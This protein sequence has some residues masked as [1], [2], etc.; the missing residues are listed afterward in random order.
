M[1]F[2]HIPETE[3]NPIPQR[4]NA[5]I[6]GLQH[7]PHS[8]GGAGTERVRRR[9]PPNFAR[10]LI[11]SP[12]SQARCCLLRRSAGAQPLRAPR[13]PGAQRSVS[14]LSRAPAR[15]TCTRV[16]E[17]AGTVMYGAVSDRRGAARLCNGAA[18]G[19]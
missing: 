15:R 12:Y 11:F 18:R 13:S 19:G 3:P 17:R 16:A 1:H 7:N 10:A 5:S 2:Q 8:S 6:T 4:A 9:Q 14:S